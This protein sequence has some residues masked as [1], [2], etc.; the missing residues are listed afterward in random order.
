MSVFV[1]MV[2]V[3]TSRMDGYWKAQAPQS[4]V[5]GAPWMVRLRSLEAGKE[6]VVE[7]FCR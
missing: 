5:C 3:H 4:G 7:V 1:G 6:T 2:I